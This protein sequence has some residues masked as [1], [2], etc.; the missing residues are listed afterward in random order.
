MILLPKRTYRFY[1]HQQY[2]IMIFGHILTTAGFCETF[3]AF[4]NCYTLS[5]LKN[6]NKNKKP[7]KSNLLLTAIHLQQFSLFFCCS[8]IAKLWESPVPTFFVSSLP[9]LSE[10]HHQSFVPSPSKPLLSLS[11]VIPIM[12][13]PWCL[14]LLYFPA[15]FQRVN[16]ASRDIFHVAS[17]TQHFPGSFPIA[18]MTSQ[19]SLL[20]PSPYSVSEGWRVPRFL[21]VSLL[22]SISLR[23][24]TVP[25]L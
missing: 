6:K 13:F 11:P 1:F 7:A 9:D 24:H 25:W 16:D 18:S 2:G 4:L 20:L 19:S 5:I 21:L 3:L 12:P 8:C 22:F 14:I 15:V 23:A 17:W 10:T